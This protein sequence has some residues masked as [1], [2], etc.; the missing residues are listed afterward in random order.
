MC[1]IMENDGPHLVVDKD[2]FVLRVVLV[3]FGVKL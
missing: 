3:L 2:I 1:E